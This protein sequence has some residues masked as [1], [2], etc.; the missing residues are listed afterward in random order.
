MTGEQRV[1]RA[2]SHSEQDAEGVFLRLQLDIELRD[3]GLGSA[4]NILGLIDVAARHDSADMPGLGD[5][6]RGFLAGDIVVRDLDLRLGSSDLDVCAGDVAGEGY[7]HVVIACN[8][9]KKASS[10]DWMPRRN[11]PQTSISHAAC[12][13]NA[14]EA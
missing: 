2:R 9:G 14:S 13:P 7:E 4:E 3:R 1:Q 11:L 5:F 12:A 6:D 8:R 10:A